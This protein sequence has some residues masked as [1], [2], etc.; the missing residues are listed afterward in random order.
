MRFVLLIPGMFL[1]LTISGQSFFNPLYIPP[2]LSGTSFSLTADT[3]SHVFYGSAST[4]TYGYN[5]SYLGPT[6]IMNRNDSVAISV[7]NNLPQET[8]VHWHGMH[9]PAWTDGGPHTAI[10]AASTWQ[11]GYKVMNAASTCWYHP[12]LHM[13]TGNQVY[14]GLAGM[15]IVKDTV[16][17][18]LNLPRSYGVDDF[19]VV[20]QDRSFNV[21][22]TLLV[23]GLA[24]S[25][26]V[27]GTAN[28]YLDAPAQVVRMRLLNGSNIRS[29]NLGFS[30]NRSFWVIA[31]D[32]GLLAQP[33]Q[34]TRLKI[35]GGE[36]YEILVDLTT[37]LGNTFYLTS[38]ASQFAN[39]E[40]G[41]SGMQ[42]GNSPLNGVD[43]PIMQINV[44]AATA[45]PVTT[46][47]ASL[48]TVSPW[49]AVNADTT[50]YKSLMG[51]GM[52]AQMSNFT[53]N[54]LTFD[55]M[56]INDTIPLNNIE[57]WEFQ[58][59]TNLAHPI[60][61]HDVTFYILTRD[62]IAPP[63]HEAAL[64]DVFY[65]MPGEIVQ[66]IMK[67]EDFADDTIP[68]MYHCHNLFHEDNGMMAQFI[69]V[70]PSTGIAETNA[71]AGT[72]VYPNPASDEVTFQGPDATAPV[73]VEVYK[74]GG[75]IVYASTETAGTVTLQTSTWSNGIYLVSILQNG[76]TRHH[77]LIV[78]H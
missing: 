77:K 53:I 8:T 45:S 63:P 24:D 48:I 66:V 40:P 12:H 42:N 73:V 46:I 67:F 60:H 14:M 38:Y 74:A 51:N 43:F 26:I 41:G 1:A 68:Y 52:F 19:P 76:T 16:E 33:Y 62:G 4:P 57:I 70:S 6:L 58:N 39:I 20:L 18:Q 50:R 2:A 7:T 9:I 65:I 78:H 32:G 72:G 22:G 17:A 13:N 61:I 47:P 36:R 15:I 3:S 64:K 49:L 31:S 37:S 25:M 69:V 71:R 27:N 10:P 54:G 28:A 30:D 5:G 75:E 21:N 44:V 34:V 56:V 11:I 35:H 59:S 23:E 29:Y 55:M